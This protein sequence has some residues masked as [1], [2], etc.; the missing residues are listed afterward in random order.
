[1]QAMIDQ[2]V[3]AAKAE[4]KGVA[5]EL[6]ERE[7]AYSRIVEGKLE[8]DAR[9]EELEEAQVQREQAVADMEVMKIM[10]V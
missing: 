4:T 9:V 3:E 6:E 8:A 5:Q 2:A 7:E 10:V 1:M